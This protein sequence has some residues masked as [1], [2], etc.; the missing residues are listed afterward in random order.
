MQNNGITTDSCYPYASYVSGDS[1]D[2]AKTC[3]NGSAI[4]ELYKSGYVNITETDQVKDFLLY[5]G[6]A[7]VLIEGMR[8]FYFLVDKLN[9]K[10]YD[11]LL[12]YQMKDAKNQEEGY[13]PLTYDSD[14]GYRALKVY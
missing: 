3:T 14:L 7:I 10:A 1:Y 9:K 13:D 12:H 2:C 4:T 8:S 5:Q 11:E 6:P